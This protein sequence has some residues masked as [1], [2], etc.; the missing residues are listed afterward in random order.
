MKRQNS[1]HEEQHRIISMDGSIIE[2]VCVAKN[3]KYMVTDEVK[4][5]KEYQ[6]RLE[7]MDIFRG[8]TL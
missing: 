5:M 3:S 4:A 6:P 1:T 7:Y 8:K 2:Y